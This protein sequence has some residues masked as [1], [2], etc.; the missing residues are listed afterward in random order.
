MARAT[1]RL[2][3]RG[4]ISITK[5]G[6][7]ADGNGLYLQVSKAGAKSWL[8][9]FASG[10]KTREM[11]LGS[12][13]TIS[14][15]DARR[16][17]EQSRKLVYEGID[18]IEARR[19]TKAARDLST[20]KVHTFQECADRLM[21]S[22][23]DEWENLKHS[24]QWQSTLE[25]YAY[26][27]MG[28][29]SVRD[30]D[31]GL[32]LEVLEPIWTTKPETAS[33]VRGR[34]EA[35]L[36]WARARNW[37]EGE[38]PA[39]WKGHLDKLLSKRKNRSVQ[40]LAALSYDKIGSFVGD[41]RGQDGISARGL[42]FLI[43]TAARTGEV[44]GARWEEIDAAN[45]IW[46]IP[47]DRMKAGKEHRV[48][49]SESAQAILNCMRS[50]RQSDFIFP[51][52]RTSRPLSNMAFLTLL[53]RMGRNEI[54]VHGF[55]STFRDWVAERTAYPSDVAEMALA[56]SIPSRVEAAYRRGDLF[57]KRRALMEE[58]ERFI[59]TPSVDAE[60]YIIPIRSGFSP[61]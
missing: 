53:K 8:F 60:S 16:A 2:S 4:V 46:T 48:P 12:L 59:A 36:D 52:G 26:P 28:K 54:T 32:V 19:A 24:K 23:G 7:H 15:S 35:V 6:L 44:I 47:A 34:I 5:P 14:L 25:T 11:G 50:V 55:R 49:L 27:V 1:N 13:T 21:R 37:R 56:H 40:N 51:G 9:K 30:I 20:I 41:L 3:A 29:L 22:K 39:R 10:G 45:G 38:N 57:D 58:W 18:P 31:V 33:R 17:A 61:S 42:E 43:L